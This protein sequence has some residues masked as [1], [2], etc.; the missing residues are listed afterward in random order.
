[1]RYFELAGSMGRVIASCVLALC[2]VGACQDTPTVVRDEPAGDQDEP[3]CTEPS[4]ER[5]VNYWHGDFDPSAPPIEVPCEVP[6]LVPFEESDGEV[7][8]LTNYRIVETEVCSQL[9]EEYQEISYGEFLLGCEL[10]S[11]LNP[12][13]YSLFG[14]LSYTR[15]AAN[16]VTTLAFRPRS[17]RHWRAGLVH[18]GRIFVTGRGQTEGS[19]FYY[20]VLDLD[21]NTCVER[22]PLGRRYNYPLPY[23]VNGHLFLTYTEQDRNV[24]RPRCVVQSISREGEA[25]GPP[26]WS[27]PP[28]FTLPRCG[29]IKADTFLGRFIQHDKG[30][31]YLRACLRGG[32]VDEWG[33]WILYGSPEGEEDTTGQLINLRALWDGQRFAMAAQWVWSTGETSIYLLFWLM[34]AHGNMLSQPVAIPDAGGNMISM[35]YDGSD[36]YLVVWAGSDSIDRFWSYFIQRFDRAGNPVGCRLR[37]RPRGIKVVLGGEGIWHNGR[38]WVANFCAGTTPYDPLYGVLLRFQLGLATD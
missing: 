36:T 26:M 35:A 21:G 23:E 17:R 25:L 1:M 4:P 15:V 12:T 24:D 27:S 28:S 16:G 19:N 34:D 38:E 30:R 2:L 8:P 22:V 3:W 6:C 20:E 33:K 10:S 13:D 18:A 5:L 11:A 9:P 37:I 14:L 29:M 7:P 31:K 32:Y